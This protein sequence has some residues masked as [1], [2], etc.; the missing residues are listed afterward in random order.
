MSAGTRIVTF[1]VAHGMEGL[2]STTHMYRDYIE[3]LSIL[4]H[5]LVSFVLEFH[6]MWEPNGIG[7]NP[8]LCREEYRVYM[9]P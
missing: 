5:D 6:F 2:P 3:R 9:L 4:S 7:N 1:P 8:L